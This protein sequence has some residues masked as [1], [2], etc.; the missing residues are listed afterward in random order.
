MSDLHSV[1]RGL[2]VD[3]ATLT[4]LTEEGADGICT[5]IVPGKNAL[6][7]WRRLCDAVPQTGHWPVFLGGKD[8][9]ARHREQV[10]DALEQTPAQIIREG[11]ALDPSVWLAAQ[12][13]EQLA[14][15][16]DGDLDDY[17]G[18]WPERE[19][20]SHE[21]SIVRDFSGLLKPALYLGLVPAIRSW[22]VPAHLKLGGWNDCPPSEIHVSLMKRW[23]ET[24]GAEIVCATHDVVEMQVS[25]PPT[26]REKALEL[27]EEQFSY[28]YDIVGQGTETLERLAAPLLNGTVWYFWWD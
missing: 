7:L 18:A 24:Y 23:A 8:D 26:T 12:K 3:A 11:L 27:A 15:D 22:E 5:L 6:T 20:A 25:R 9:L 4:P 13:V 10:E 19:Q 2:G 28:C 17:H 21:L 14:D 16:E 1:L